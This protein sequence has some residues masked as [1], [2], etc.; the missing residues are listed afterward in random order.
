[1]V[2]RVRPHEAFAVTFHR[3]GREIDLMV[4]RT[5]EDAR[6]AALKMIGQ[7]NELQDGDMLRC[8]EE[9]L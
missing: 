8:T 1:M 4:A 9:S 7:L 2:A 5:G 3:D 6:N